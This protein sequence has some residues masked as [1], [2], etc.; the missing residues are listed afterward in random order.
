V[1]SNVVL[2]CFCLLANLHDRS[3]KGLLAQQIVQKVFELD[4]PG[5]FLELHPDGSWRK[6]PLR[7][8]I[9]KASQALREKK[10]DKQLAQLQS[11]QQE[12]QSEALTS[13]SSSSSTSQEQSQEEVK[14]EEKI[15][16]YDFCLDQVDEQHEFE[17][18]PAT[19]DSAASVFAV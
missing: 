14:G 6:V 16:N 4:P 7:T 5:R 18:V 15:Y 12:Q 3:Q 10:W 2:S 8:A 19:D 17:S 1:T 13:S 11:Q 9:D